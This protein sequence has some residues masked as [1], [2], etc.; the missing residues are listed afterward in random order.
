MGHTNTVQIYQANMAFI[1]QDKIPHRTMPF[2]DDLLVKSK[3]SQYQRPDSL[4]EMIPENPG[5]PDT[6]DFEDWLDNFY[7]FCVTLLNDWLLPSSTTPCS[8][9]CKYCM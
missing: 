7:S 6:D 5:I 4:Y 9:E 1:L 3:T 8:I 2:I